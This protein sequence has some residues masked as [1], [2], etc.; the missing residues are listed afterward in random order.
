[1]ECSI[2]NVINL[3][4]SNNMF[5]NR[6][7]NFEVEYFDSLVET[8]PSHKQSNIMNCVGDSN[9]YLNFVILL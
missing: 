8:I 9:I 3:D 2:L 4:S 1:M 7:Q 6:T 5:I